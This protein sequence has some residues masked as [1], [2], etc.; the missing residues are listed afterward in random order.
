MSKSSTPP[1][2]KKLSRLGLHSLVRAACVASLLSM[3]LMC[4]SVFDPT[5]FPVMVSMTVGQGIGTLSLAC[6]LAA[7]LVAQWRRERPSLAP[8]KPDAKGPTP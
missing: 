5:P 3:A 1:P 8:P 4:W 2:I 7:V 6:Y